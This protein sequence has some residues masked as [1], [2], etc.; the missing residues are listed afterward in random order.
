MIK[1]VGFI[2][3]FQIWKKYLLFLI[4]TCLI[5]ISI[6]AFIANKVLIPKYT[7]SNQILISQMNTEKN[8]IQNTDIEA[9]IRLVNTY[10]VLIKS[11]KVLS[12]VNKSLDNKFSYK[13]L[14]SKIAV[15]NVENSQIINI[16]VTDENPEGA[17]LIVNEVTKSFKKIT[18]TIMK[19]DNINILSQAEVPVNPAPISPNKLLTILL[20]GLISLVLAVMLIFVRELLSNKIDKEEDISNLLDI[21]V[22]GE[23]GKIK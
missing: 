11:Q 8:E 19:V 21:P 10:S 13:E 12:D 6:A 17:V 16:S 4:I 9:A 2:E 5:G 1:E 22:F 20:G 3:I 23:I 15:D 18:P 7:M 14:A